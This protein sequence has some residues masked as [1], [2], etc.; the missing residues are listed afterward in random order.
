MVNMVG[1]IIEEQNDLS[2]FVL[3]AFSQLGEDGGEV[4]SK[5]GCI[6]ASFN[7]LEANYLLSCDSC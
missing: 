3:F 4:V 2:A 6:D 5:Q 1:A 7:N